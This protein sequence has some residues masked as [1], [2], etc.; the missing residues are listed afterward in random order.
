MRRP[1][2]LS[3]LTGLLDFG[4]AEQLRRRVVSRPN[5]FLTQVPV[6]SIRTGHTMHAGLAISR[7]Q[8]VFSQVRSDITEDYVEDS[9]PEREERRLR[10]ETRRTKTRAQTRS[11]PVV[12]VA[13]VI[14]LT[15]SDGSAVQVHQSLQSDH[16]NPIVIIDVPESYPSADGHGDAQPHSGDGGSERELSRD[17]TV[18]D[19]LPSIRKILGLP[20]ARPAVRAEEGHTGGPVSPSPSRDDL[21]PLS[22][23]SSTEGSDDEGEDLLKLVQFAYAAPPPLRRTASNTLSPSE[24]ERDVRP[25]PARIKRV[26][27]TTAYT[28]ATG[29]TDAALSQLRKCVSCEQAWT[30]RKTVAHKLK[31]IQTCAKKNKLSGA[32]LQTLLRKELDSLPPVASTSK[33]PA[34]PSPAPPATET[35]LENVLKDAQRKKTGRRPQVLQTVKSIS[36]TRD[37]ILDRARVLLEDTCDTVCSKNETTAIQRPLP[38]P[39]LDIPPTTQAF[40]RSNVAV[41][42]KSLEVHPADAT[43]VFGSSRLGPAQPSRAQAGIVRAGAAIAAHSDVS[44]LTQVFSGGSSGVARASSPVEE[45]PPSTQVFALSKFANAGAASRRVVVANDDPMDE[46]ISIHDTSEDDLQK[47]SPNRPLK[48]KPSSSISRQSTEPLKRRASYS[49]TRPISVP[50]STSIQAQKPIA[51]W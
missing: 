17:T 5:H 20:K 3:R 47:S 34:G 49:P 35:L 48:R 27:T 26:P 50:G 36:E 15:D 42:N 13:S 10:K 29:F 21:A 30:V 41:R 7:S 12:P 37:N 51:R 33:A 2:S 9:E 28:F 14:E 16:L 39:D 43:V 11:Q 22:S 32:T 31:H 1:S 25:I 6:P 23:P 46:P 38:P 40:T 18:E 19:S 24:S 45:M 44:P 4:G 8:S